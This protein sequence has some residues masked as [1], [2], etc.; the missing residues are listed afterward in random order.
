MIL[1]C[2]LDGNI[3]QVN[4]LVCIYSCPKKTKVKCQAY[5]KDFE[6]LEAL[7]IEDKYIYK[8]GAPQF[9]VPNAKKK[10][11]AKDMVAKILKKVKPKPPEAAPAL[12]AESVKPKRTRR[13]KAQMEEARKK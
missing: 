12:A 1:V 3:H 6:K 7:I 4:A 11:K 5:D 13:T 2:S 8:Y 9:P 10:K